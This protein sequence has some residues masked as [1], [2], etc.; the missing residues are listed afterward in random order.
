M[1]VFCYKCQAKAIKHHG[2]D[3]FENGC[4]SCKKLCCC[5]NKKVGYTSC[6]FAHYHCYKKCIIYKNKFLPRGY[7]KKHNNY[8]NNSN[9]NSNNNNNNNNNNNDNSN[10]DNSSLR[11]DNN[12]NKDESRYGNENGRIEKCVIDNSDSSSSEGIISLSNCADALIKHMYSSN[13]CVGEYTCVNSNYFDTN[14][15][16]GPLKSSGSS[17]ID[18]VDALDILDYEYEDY[19]NQ[20]AILKEMDSSASDFSYGGTL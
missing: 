8:N 12:N 10:N 13:P 5:Y 2:D 7:A 20:D 19:V 14:S 9:N 17:I 18:E 6:S 1:Q 15:F 3:V 16:D 11:N 4:I